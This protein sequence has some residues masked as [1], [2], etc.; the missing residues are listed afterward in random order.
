MAGAFVPQTTG[1]QDCTDKLV[2][3]TKSTLLRN[4]LLTLG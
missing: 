4:N 2:T 3:G 1:A